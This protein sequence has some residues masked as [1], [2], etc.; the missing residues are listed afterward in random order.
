MLILIKIRLFFLMWFVILF[1]LLLLLCLDSVLWNRCCVSEEKIEMKN[2]VVECSVCHSKLV[3]P[4]ARS[5]SKAY[6]RHKIRVSSKQ[7]A[8]NVLLVVGDCMLVGLQVRDFDS[9]CGLLVL[10]M[11]DC[12]IYIRSSTWNAC[13]VTL[14]I[15]EM[16]WILSHYLFVILFCFS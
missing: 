7:R 1:L 10:L 2:G 16:D 15:C 3:S 4:S 5:Y 6:D 14:L 8:L 12:G 13:F 9:W 11:L